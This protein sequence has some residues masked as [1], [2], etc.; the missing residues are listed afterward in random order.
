MTVLIVAHRL[1]T[2]RNADKIFVIQNGKVVEEGNHTDLLKNPSGAYT[3][4]ISRQMQAQDKLESGTSPTKSL[5][6]RSKGSPISPQPTSRRPSNTSSAPESPRSISSR[7]SPIV[8]PFSGP[9]PNARRSNTAQEE[10]DR[11][12]SAGKSGLK[13]LAGKNSHSQ[14]GGSNGTSPSPTMG[15]RKGNGST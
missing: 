11:R 14:N 8:S 15:S 12:R 9:S 1:S 5:I 7:P 3:S 6:E 2:V 4:L 10:A 13:T